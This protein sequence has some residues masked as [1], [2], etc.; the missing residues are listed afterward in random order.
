MTSPDLRELNRIGMRIDRVRRL[1]GAIGT[2]R[3]RVSFDRWAA[4]QW[5]VYSIQR[6]DYGQAAAGI[7]RAYGVRGMEVYRRLSVRHTVLTISVEVSR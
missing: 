1:R 2:H 5:A 3:G 7:L 4:R 6:G